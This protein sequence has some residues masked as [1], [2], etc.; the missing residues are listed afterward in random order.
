MTLSDPVLGPGS[1]DKELPGDDNPYAGRI[2]THR[3]MGIWDWYEEKDPD[4]SAVSLLS[5]SGWSESCCHLGRSF[6]YVVRAVK[7]VLG[8]PGCKTQFAVYLATGFGAALLPAATIWSQG[9]ILRVM[10]D[11]NQTST[12]DAHRLL[13]ACAGRI[14]CTIATTALHQMQGLSTGRHS[15]VWQALQ[16]TIRMFSTG[17]RLVTQTIALI[18]VLRGHSE[19]RWLTWMTLAIELLASV[20][21]LRT[22]GGTAYAATTRNIDYKRKR[23]WEM[24]VQRTDH[25]KE[26]VAGNLAEYAIAE[27][28]R[29]SD[30]LGDENVDWTEIYRQELDKASP[31]LLGYFNRW[32]LPHLTEVKNPT[33]L[34][35][36]MARLNL[37]Q[38][39]ARDVGVSFSIVINT[40]NVIQGHIDTLRKTYE[41]ENIRNVVQDGTVPFQIE[42]AQAT[43]GVA[44]EFSLRFKT[45]PLPCVR[46]NFVIVGSNGAGKSTILKL[47]VRLYDPDEGEILLGGRD[48]RTLKLR[49]VRQAMSVLFQDYTHFPF[50]IRDNIVLGDPS[51]AHD[52]AH[53]R[54]AARLGGADSFIEKLPEGY[55]TYLKRVVGDF[56]SGPA[57]GNKTRSGKPFDV[58]AVQHAAGIKST[59]SSE[60][61]GGQMQRLAVARMFMRSVVAED[62]RVGLL[63]FDEPSASL[64]PAAEHDLFNRLR[65]LRGN[66]TMVFSS[67][68]FGNL[69]RH[70][71]VILYMNE[72]SIVESG[73]HEE[74]LKDQG[75][76]QPPDIASENKVSES[77]GDDNPYAGRIVKHQRIGVWDWYE[78]KDPDGAQLISP[79]LGWGDSYSDIAGS[80]RYVVRLV[81]DLLSIPGCKT[82]FAIYMAAGFG[83]ALI[84]AAAIWVQGNILRVMD[85]INQTSTVDTQRLFQAC[86][87]KIACTIASSVL[88]QIRRKANVKLDRRIQQWHARRSFEARARLDLPTFSLQS[89][90]TAL[91]GLSSGGHSMIWQGLQMTIGMFTTGVRLVTQ[92]IALID[93]LR[94]HDQERL[95][96]WIT[97]AAE[98]LALLPQLSVR[99]SLAC[100]ATTKNSDYKRMKGW[101]VIVQDPD[102][103]KELVAGNLAEFATAEYTR[104]A[105]SLGD[106][107][108]NWMEAFHERLFQQPLF[109]QY[110]NTWILGHLS[111]IIF[112]LRAVRNPTRLP[113]F[114]ARLNLVQTSAR[115]VAWTFAGVLTN[116]TMV[117]AN[118]DTIRS[119][120][121][122]VNIRNIV[123]DGS[124]PFQVE[125][126]EATSGVA[127]EFRNVTFTY[128]EAS[129]PALQNVSFT[130]SPGQLCVIVGSNGAGKST[131]LKL[132][133]RL[134]DPDEGEILFGG[135]DIRTLKLS[136]VRQAMSVLFQDYTHFPLSIR[137]NIALGDPSKASDGA[138]IREAARLGGADSFIEKLPEGFDTYLNPVVQDFVSGP[139]EG[140]RTRSGKPFD[141]CA[142]RHA[143]GIKSSTSSELSGGQMQRLAVARTFMRSVVAE[144][145][146][147]GLLLFDE[148]SASLD[149][150]AEHDLFNRLRRLRGNK[151]MVFSSHRFG[152][153]TRHADLIL[154]MNESSIVES[155]THEE[156]LKGQGEYAKLWQM[157]AQAFVS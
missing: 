140:D 50:S 102:H 49:D 92:T 10:D 87:G 94:G 132:A 67:H 29:A 79:A 81:K 66:K 101:E 72:S 32:I 125:S 90:Q 63:L 118:L 76:D 64:D 107:D 9:N 15:M 2:V 34:P 138:H 27:Y 133:V 17:V 41:T 111:E 155:G 75:D 13:L 73:T 99:A 71:D 36:F 156:L 14:A 124:V 8:I 28:T 5:P 23:G 154:Y 137:D 100:A 106:D 116:K 153:L 89:T 40:R 39:S 108:V 21:R 146:R 91:A 22:R 35:E 61:S 68:R 103:R 26:L 134:Y 115:G 53:I 25:R 58:C 52:D 149:P 78:E 59:T 86:A 131:I 142:V 129:K 122:A 56:V 82:Q 46:V 104:T 119:T 135:Q 19:E 120:Y 85:D 105:D 117:K 74:L 141:V 60:L 30:S 44:L 112:I 77:P 109:Q 98:S 65:K 95:L 145:R 18:D 113:E 4:A 55:N 11:I 110:F 45:P 148:P 3:R 7:D 93:V 126:A 123:P 70:A 157:Q 121:E 51:K 147:V 114:M 33:R 150:A 47:A 84:P 43:S 12:V 139:A 20:P 6:Q 1:K 88:E 24:V 143:A 130:L 83:A 16:V 144:D 96:T 42:S 62:N 57:E 69:T 80:L 38:T 97:L 128:P 151:T 152:N 127:L 31:S 54:E 37:V 48:I 136:D